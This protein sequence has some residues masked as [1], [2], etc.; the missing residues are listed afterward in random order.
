[1]VSKSA[2]IMTNENINP[3]ITHIQKHFKTWST[4][5]LSWLERVAGVK[6]VLLPKLIFVFLN[7][8]LDILARTLNRIQSLLN[9]FIWDNKKPRRKFSITNKRLQ[10]GGVAI[11]NIRKYY[12]ASRRQHVM[13]EDDRMMIYFCY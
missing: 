3:F 1:M 2:Y 9:K 11:P 8:F 13:V 10:N 4:Y 6:M 5:K 7:A 12:E